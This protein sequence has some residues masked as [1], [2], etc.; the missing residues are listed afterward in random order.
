MTVATI[1]TI[2]TFDTSKL[3]LLVCPLD[4]TGLRGTIIKGIAGPELS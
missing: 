4:F 1:D 3:F 2:N